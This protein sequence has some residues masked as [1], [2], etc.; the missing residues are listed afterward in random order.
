M[1]SARG[2]PLYLALA[3]RLAACAPSPAVAAFL[4]ARVGG[5]WGA[6]GAASVREAPRERSVC[7]GE[8]LCEGAEV[9]IGVVVA[10][11]V[12]V[13]EDAEHHTQ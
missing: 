9:A 8:C 4:G 1:R 13:V 7:G 11:R 2:G 10:S 12:V 5:L 6:A 3:K